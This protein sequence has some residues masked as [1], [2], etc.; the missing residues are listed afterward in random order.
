MDFAALRAKGVTPRASR[1]G[2]LSGWRLRFNVEHFF[3]HEGGVGNVERTGNADDAVCGVLH[4]CDDADLAALDK[5]EGYGVGYDRIEVPIET[6]AGT[7]T[8]FTYVGLPAYVNDTCLP[9]RRYINIL[10]RGAR[11]AGLA[12]DYIA[13]LEQQT[14]LPPVLRPAFAP[15]PTGRTMSHTALE[16][17]HTVL[18]G[19]V[20]CMK[21]VRFAHEL[22]RV[23]FGGKDVTQFHLRRMD[24]STGAEDLRSF[25]DGDL[26]PD[27]RD[28][29]NV[30]LHAF[31]EEYRHI[32]QFDYTDLP[33]AKILA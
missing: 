27:Q 11:A 32:G 3:R 31:N 30:Y 22:A 14:L 21:E 7:E 13:A 20:F 1:W 15:T 16:T 12:P 25:L 33:N 17:D 9:T 10:V 5:L 2:R 8:A 4:V 6:A 29:L 24:Q 28:F 19:H 23:W 26:R 18:A